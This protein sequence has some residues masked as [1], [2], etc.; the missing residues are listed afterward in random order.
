MGG[1][2][3]DNDNDNEEE[4]DWEKLANF[5]WSCLYRLVLQV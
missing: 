3:D 1:V 4:A 2:S 5:L